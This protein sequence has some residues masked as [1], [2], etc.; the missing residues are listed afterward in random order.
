MQER[1]SLIA[2]ISK[3]FVGTPAEYKQL[4][5]SLPGKTEVELE[6][7]AA[8]LQMLLAQREKTKLD[9][10][11]QGLAVSDRNWSLIDHKLGPYYSTQ[12]FRDAITQDQ[13]FKS[14]LKWDNEPFAELVQ[15]EQRQ[16]QFEQQQ[17]ALFVV[18]A[19]AATAQGRNIAPNQANYQMVKEA[20]EWGTSDREAQGFTL[21]N[22]LALLFSNTLQ[23]APNEHEVAAQ[24]V[25]ER[26]DAERDRLAEIVVSAMRSWQ[27]QG[28]GGSIVHDEYGRDQALKKIKQL[29]LDELR[30]KAQVIDHNRKTASMSS[31]QL[32]AQ[33]EHDRQEQHR[34]HGGVLTGKPPLPEVNQHGERIDSAYL[35]RISNTNLDLFKRL[36]LKHGYQ[37]VTNRIQGRG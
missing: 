13:A 2:Q 24:L 28:P 16:Q 37:N 14:S 7:V 5:D 27:T 20:L 21:P 9:L 31:V 18:A 23:L 17:F 22:V 19:K 35:V 12:Q 10:V 15:A 8:Q 11:R 1:T 6:R 30:A 33:A 32:R 3:L 26:D 4:M 34:N 29:S 25:Q 36:V